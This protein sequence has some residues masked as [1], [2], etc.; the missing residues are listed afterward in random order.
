MDRVVQY[1][2][3][4]GGA[5]TMAGSSGTRIGN[6]ADG[7]APRDAVNLGQ[8]EHAGATTLASANQHADIAAGQA[9][10]G[11]NAYTDTA[12]AKTLASANDYADEASANTLSS[13]NAYTDRR[14]SEVTS[15][16]LQA[17]DDLR[18]DMD[19]R[20]QRQDRRIDRQGAMGSAMLNMAINAAGTQSPRGRVAVGAGFQG[21]ESALS[22]GYGK[23]IGT[24]ASFS[25]GG[26]FSGSEK[27]GGIGFGIDL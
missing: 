12:S 20:L 14:F 15:M 11:A 1:D 21:G 6:V 2:A 9:F 7:Q 8:M 26:A 10:E 23:R 27:S 16:P 25:L 3:D 19:W 4:D 24:R 17:I 5:I 18:A 13:A 22:V